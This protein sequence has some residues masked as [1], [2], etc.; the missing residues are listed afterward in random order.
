MPH[1]DKVTPPKND[2]EYFERM[3]KSLFSAGLNWSV[4]DN[5]WSNFQKAF[6]GFSIPKVAK[7]SEKQAARL[8][9]DAGIVR[10]EK[11]ISATIFNAKAAAEVSREF[12]SFKKYLQSFPKDED[13]LQADLQRRFR[14]LGPSSARTFLWSV[15]HPLTP[16]AE[17][18]K[19]LAAQ[20]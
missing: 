20:K 18:K 10:N 8:K 13:A 17:E 5:K 12:G 15:G 7:F 1:P 19:W 4:I 16:N 3:T 6:A 11:K 14:H 2:D 9:E